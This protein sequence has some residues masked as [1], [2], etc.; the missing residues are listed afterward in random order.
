VADPTPEGTPVPPPRQAQQG[1]IP[2]RMIGFGVLAL[3]GVL[4]VILNSGEVELHFVFW[5]TKASLVIL[6]LIVLA[7]GFLAGFLFDTVRGR[8]KSRRSTSPAS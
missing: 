2:W 8:R 4:L 7:V 5:S 3:Y 1:G 6:L